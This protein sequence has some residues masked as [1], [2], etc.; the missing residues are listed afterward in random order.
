MNVLLDTNVLVYLYDPLQAFKQEQARLTLRALAGTGLGFISTQVLSEFFSVITTRLRP[1]ISPEIALIEIERHVR[2]FKVLD[3]TV[4]VIIAAA[5][6]VSKHSLNF[7]DAQ[8][9]AAAK[10]NGID[11]IF[12]EDFNTGSSLGG[13]RFVNPFAHGFHPSAWLA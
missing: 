9:W 2:V 12:S 1:R 4:P 11:A 10:L 3:V 7:W 5:H 13:V 6:A 8:L